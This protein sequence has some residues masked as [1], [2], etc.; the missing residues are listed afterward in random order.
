MT[1]ISHGMGLRAESCQMKAYHNLIIK[2]ETTRPVTDLPRSR[3]PWKWCPSSRGSSSKSGQL[4][5]ISNTNVIFKRLQM[6]YTRVWTFFARFQ[7]C[8]HIIFELKKAGL[9]SRYNFSLGV[10]ALMKIEP[11]FNRHM[12]HFTVESVFKTVQSDL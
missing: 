10:I 3:R 6:P 7:K 2:F 5:A 9:T 1:K 11:L 12:P 8:I 4:G